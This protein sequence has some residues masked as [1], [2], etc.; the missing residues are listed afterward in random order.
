MFFS[1]IITFNNYYLLLVKFFC[2]SFYH[3]FDLPLQKFQFINDSYLD[4]PLTHNNQLL[5]PS[6]LHTI[7][8]DSKNTMDPA[9]M[10]HRKSEEKKVSRPGLVIFSPSYLSIIFAPAPSPRPTTCFT[11]RWSRTVTRFR[12]IACKRSSLGK[13]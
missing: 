6:T 9:R 5:I 2:R 10:I 13:R 3:F 12:P 11:L 1:D 8:V 7:C 4:C